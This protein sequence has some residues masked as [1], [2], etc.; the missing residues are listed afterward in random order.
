MEKLILRVG[1]HAHMEPTLIGGDE[2]AC[3]KAD[4]ETLKYYVG[5]MHYIELKNGLTAIR[6]VEDIGESI[7]IKCDSGDNSQTIPKNYVQAI[8]RVIASLRRY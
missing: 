5:Y 6:R 1:S 8:Y 7:K 2:I 4:L 3:I